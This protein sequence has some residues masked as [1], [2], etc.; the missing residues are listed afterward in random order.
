[1][2]HRLICRT[3][4]YICTGTAAPDGTI[5]KSGRT[6]PASALVQRP[7]GRALYKKITLKPPEKDGL[8][9]GVKVRMI[10][11]LQMKLVEKHI[12]P[13]LVRSVQKKKFLSTYL[14]EE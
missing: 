14:T 6:G 3:T 9:L 8:F 10:T 2:E 12:N 4:P 5:S 7:A 11:C 1:M 13:L